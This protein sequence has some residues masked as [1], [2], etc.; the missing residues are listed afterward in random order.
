LLTVLPHGVQQLALVVDEGEARTKAIMKL[1]R[2]T[3]LD[4]R[5]GWYIPVE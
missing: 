4:H 1:Y 3:D 5:R 2:G